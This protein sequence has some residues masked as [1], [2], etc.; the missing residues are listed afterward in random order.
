MC[1]CASLSL[2]PSISLFPS[3][4]FSLHPSLFLPPSLSFSFHPSLFL[5]LSPSLSYPLSPPLSFPL[6][7]SLSPSVVCVVS[8]AL[9]RSPSLTVR[10]NILVSTCVYMVGCHIGEHLSTVA[11][12]C[13]YWGPVCVCVCVTPLALRPP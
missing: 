12:V 6:S 13:A 8:V 5:P 4:S 7:P 2:S 10:D 9:S 3:L 1:V 11:C